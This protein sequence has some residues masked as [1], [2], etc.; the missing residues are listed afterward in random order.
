MI[1]LPCPADAPFAVAG[2]E[3]TNVG[4]VVRAIFEQPERTLGTWVSCESEKLSCRQWVEALG[5]AAQAQGLDGSVEFEECSM[6]PFEDKWGV[7]G[8]EC[9]LM[10]QYIAAEQERSFLNT[11][12]LPEVTVKDLGLDTGLISARELYHNTDCGALFRSAE[13]GTPRFGTI[14]VKD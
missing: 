11:S 13:D 4:L 12:G 3:K 2:D 5:S 10:F 7:V 14:G 1:R 6:Q 9:G 8:A